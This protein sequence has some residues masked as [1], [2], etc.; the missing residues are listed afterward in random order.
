MES[1]YET[2]DLFQ[3]TLENV[4]TESRNPFTNG[5]HT[6]MVYIDSGT[7]PEQAIKFVAEAVLD[8]RLK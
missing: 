8:R 2:P 1:I 5:F 4:Y 7:E 3:Y 6:F